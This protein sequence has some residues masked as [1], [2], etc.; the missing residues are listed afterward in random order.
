MDVVAQ[1]SLR[2]SRQCAQ[3]LQYCLRIGWSRSS[4]DRLQALW[5][6][7]HSLET[8]ELLI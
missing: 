7:Y 6:Q 8:G 1:P 4:L 2:A 3:W 5:W